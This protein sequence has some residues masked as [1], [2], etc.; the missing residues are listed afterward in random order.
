[1]SPSGVKAAVAY[2][3]NQEEHHRKLP[4]HEFPNPRAPQPPGPG[5]EG[6]GWM[7][8]LALG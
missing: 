2:I 3:Q 7:A 8:Q 5:G 4:F 6:L 1:V